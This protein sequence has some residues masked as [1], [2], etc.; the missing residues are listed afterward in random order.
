[1]GR[2]P[3]YNYLPI[4]YLSNNQLQ[5]IYLFNI[6]QLFKPYVILTIKYISPLFIKYIPSLFT[7]YFSFLFIKYISSPLI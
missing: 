5:K 2:Q 6:V 1:M 3:L 7:D 4:K